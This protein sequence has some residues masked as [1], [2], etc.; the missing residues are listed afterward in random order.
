VPLEY[1]AAWS[2]GITLFFAV[3]FLLFALITRGTRFALG[4]KRRLEGEFC[5]EILRERLARGDITE[6]QFS[7]AR[8]ALGT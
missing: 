5:M 7:E 3:V 2:I 8:R 1:I 6:E 4:P